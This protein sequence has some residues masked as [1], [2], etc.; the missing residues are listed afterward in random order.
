MFIP[1]VSDT[2]RWRGMARDKPHDEGVLRQN[3]KPL[4]PEL[5]NVTEFGADIRDPPPRKAAKDGICGGPTISMAGWPGRSFIFRQVPATSSPM[6]LKRRAPFYFTWGNGII[7]TQVS[8][9]IDFRHQA[10][11]TSA[12]PDAEGICIDRWITG[13]TTKSD[14]GRWSAPAGAVLLL[15]WKNLLIS[16]G[17]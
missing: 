9:S 11:S 12:D 7:M 17:R 1:P 15:S 4:R 13:C 10:E 2:A 5:F 6:V 3:E 16:L 14:D 8:R